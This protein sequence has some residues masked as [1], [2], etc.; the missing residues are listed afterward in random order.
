MLHLENETQELRDKLIAMWDLVIKQLDKTELAFRTFDRDLALEIQ[1]TEKRV[2]AY[3]LT[4]DRSCEDFIALLQ[5]VASDLRFVLS[6]LKINTNLERVGDIA[7]GVSEFISDTE[8]SF[9]AEIISIMEADKMLAIAIEMIKELRQSYLL[10]NTKLARTVYKRDK[11]LDKL[12][13]MASYKALE[14]LDKF[15]DQRRQT[16]HVLSIIRKL[17]R[18]GDQSKNIAEEIIFFLEAKVLKHKGREEKD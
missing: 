18:I 5:P 15:P 10:E 14:C 4:I 3:E 16:L 2:N 1:E 13:D 8:E 6:S 9:N 17:E 11:M 12:N 7:C